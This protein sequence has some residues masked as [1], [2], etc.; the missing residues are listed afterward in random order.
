MAQDGRREISVRN[1]DDFLS[2][3]GPVWRPRWSPCRSF[4]RAFFRRLFS[5]WI[6]EASGLDLGAHFGDFREPEG[7]REAKTRFNEKYGLAEAKPM[8][9]RGGGLPRS[10]K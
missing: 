7:A 10:S 5:V 9:S 3:L 2:D 4:F 6:L 8:F 1:F